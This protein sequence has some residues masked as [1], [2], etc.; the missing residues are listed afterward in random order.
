MEQD[1]EGILKRQ[2][3]GYYIELFFCTIESGGKKA[4]FKLD[5]REY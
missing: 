2:Q 1:Y 5:M 4:F 3:N